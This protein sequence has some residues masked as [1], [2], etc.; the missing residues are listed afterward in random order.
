MTRVG[1]PVERRVAV[2]VADVR[3]GAARQQELHDLEVARGG[4]EVQG[5]EATAV[6]AVDVDALVGEQLRW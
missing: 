6:A 1:G 2:A 5:R 3:V 4:S